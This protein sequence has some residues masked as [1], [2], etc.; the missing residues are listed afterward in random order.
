MRRRRY[1]HGPTCPRN[2]NVR[3]QPRGSGRQGNMRLALCRYRPT[4]YRCHRRV[5]DR[6]QSRE[7]R[8]GTCRHRILWALNDCP[9]RREHRCLLWLL[10]FYVVMQCLDQGAAYAVF[11]VERCVV[12]TSSLS[13]AA[14]TGSTQPIQEQPRCS[15][16]SAVSA[17]N[18][19]KAGQ[20]N[21]GAVTISDFRLDHLSAPGFCRAFLS[22]LGRKPSWKISTKN[23][24]RV[25]LVPHTETV[26]LCDQA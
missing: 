5:G 26:S 25:I 24:K 16:I 7:S 10:R 3:V 6:S 18:Y 23:R 11:S 21:P 9:G 12:C 2:E 13:R 22:G 4:R 1:A 14:Y 19:T 15:I 17:T 20:S 8:P